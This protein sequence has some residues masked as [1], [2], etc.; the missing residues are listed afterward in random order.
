MNR[1]LSITASVLL[2]IQAMTAAQ[3][4][5][6][7]P[8]LHINTQNNEQITTKEYY[9]SA[10]YWLDTKGHDDIE[11]LGTEQAPLPLQ[12]RG[13]GNY[14]WTGFNKKPYRLK[15]EKKA[16]LLGCKKSKH[17]ALLAHADDN[18]GF[19]RNRVGLE[20]SR[21]LNLAWTP[22]DKPVEV[23][24]NGEYIGL[25][26]LTETIRV[27][28]DR[29]NVVEQADNITDPEA[30]TGGWLV[31]IDN[32]DSDPHVKIKEDEENDIIFTYKTPE[33]L[34]AEQE[35]WLRDEM[36]EINSMIYADDKADCRWSKKIDLDALARYYVVQEIVDDYESFHGS[37]YLHRQLGA[38]SKWVFGPVWDFGS[39][40]FGNTKNSFIS[41]DRNWHQT[42]I[43]E[44]V[45]F[46]EFMDAVRKVWNEFYTTHRYDIL[47]YV[48]NSCQTIAEAARADAERWP[49]Y[50]NPNVIERGQQ[51]RNWLDHSMRW[52][53]NHWGSADPVNSVTVYFEDNNE[54][55][56]ENVYAYSWDNGFFAYGDWPGT[57]CKRI[58][59]FG[60][61]PTWSITVSL[62]KELSS[63][64]GLIFNNGDS[65]KGNQTEDFILIP[66]GIYRMEG[67]HS[68]VENVTADKQPTIT[69]IS[70]C[71]VTLSLPT[72]ATVTFTR[73]DGRTTPFN[74]TAGTHTV[75]L[76]EGIYIVAGRKILLR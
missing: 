43:G 16:P 29:V 65:G 68:G 8:V 36:T 24:L 59:N 54:E 13:R 27:D 3:P 35:A 15:L 37:C 41:S 1:F 10:T 7:L 21:L 57:R 19:M 53:N 4:S 26:F 60:A 32:Y 48:D 18:F 56:W 2:S 39:A 62:D 20:L 69:A 66:G 9:L 17:F 71:N 23:V 40:G 31:E 25:Y 30:I 70:G 72:D 49:E 64:A 61:Y 58:E 73:P 28:A 63:G 76:S 14:T 55:P 12:I 33:I 34:S 22:A 47:Q 5:N 44:M 51:V 75:T 11:A 38:D 52:L 67:Y 46:P 6:T 50:G 74:L 42:W 45:K